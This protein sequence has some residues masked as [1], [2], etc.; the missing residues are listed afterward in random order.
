[1]NKLRFV[2]PKG[3]LQKDTMAL[4]KQAGYKLVGSDR[5]Y[6]PYINDSEVELKILRPQEIPNLIAQD[7]YDLGI[8]GI[9]WTQES[10][11][12]DDVVDILD[13][14]YGRVELVVAVPRDWEDIK[15]F[16]DLLKRFLN[17]GKPVRI[18]T[19]LIATTKK[20][21]MDNP[22]YKNRFGNKTPEII[23][24]W[25]R[26]GEISKVKIILS[27]GAT[28]AKPPED[29]EVIIDLTATGKT[30]EENNLKIIDSI[31]TSTARL[32][33]NRK[34]LED[35]WKRAKIQDIKMLLRGVVEARKKLHIFMNIKNENLEKLLKELP[36]LK[37]PT[38]APLSGIESWSAINTIIPKDTFMKL[39]PVLRK[40][41][42]GIVI[43]EPRQ[44]IPSEEED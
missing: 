17:S 39:I 30:I 29:A 3:S 32:L 42:Q 7:A 8:S 16:S 15:N 33:A 18:F 10:G 5:S 9:D 26:N 44:I 12:S 19:E 28:E 36:A 21:I 2:I 41:A 14:E 6:R 37:R 4:L 1:M 11:V 23:T 27:F 35:P 22:V 34:A 20:Y 40:Y 38:I 13:L 43:H 31:V 24:P 25:S